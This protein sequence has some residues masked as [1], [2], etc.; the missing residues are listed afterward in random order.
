MKHS[1]AGLLK[2]TRSS[3]FIRG[4][5]FPICMEA[6]QTRLTFKPSIITSGGTQSKFYIDLAA[7]LTAVNR[8]QYHQV[9]KDGTALAYHFTVSMKTADRT[10][11][12]CTATNNWTTANAVKKASVGWKKQLRHGGIRLDDLPPYAKRPRFALDAGMVS[13]TNED[14]ALKNTLIPIDCKGTSL[15]AAYDAPDS[16]S[17]TFSNSNEITAVP[18]TNTSGDDAGSFRMMLCGD[19]VVG[20]YQFGVLCEY[21]KSRRNMG[22]Q[23]TIPEDE[24]P[25]LDGYMLQL[26]ATA[27]EL[28]DDII[29]AVDGYNI[30]RPYNDAGICNLVPGGNIS[31]AGGVRLPFSMSGVAPLGLLYLETDESSPELSEFYID[32][33]AITEMS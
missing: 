28:S 21:L 19:T 24:F 15:F 3:I 33:E 4:T 13:A 29:S 2:I 1:L 16:T 31:S 27:E 26:F 5:L 32:V 20:D 14:L 7:A 11:K 23:P 8:K 18:L 30:Y 17:I 12:W 9:Q 22:S 6:S 25:D 10:L